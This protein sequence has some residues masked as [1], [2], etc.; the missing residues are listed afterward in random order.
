MINLVS[1]CRVDEFSLSVN[2]APGTELMND[3]ILFDE[4]ADIYLISLMPSNIV[5]YVFFDN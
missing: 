3:L 1:M 2:D 4:A 5:L